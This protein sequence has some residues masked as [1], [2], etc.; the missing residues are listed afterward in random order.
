MSKISFTRFEPDAND[1]DSVLIEEFREEIDEEEFMEF[2]STLDIEKC[3]DPSIDAPSCNYDCDNCEIECELV[4]KDQPGKEISLNVPLMLEK[5][6]KHWI[7][8][9]EVAEI[10][11][12][13]KNLYFS[14]LNS[15]IICLHEMFYY[16]ICD[17]G[18]IDLSSCVVVADTS[19][20]VEL[21]FRFC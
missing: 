18:E 12:M 5:F 21:D 16:S 2:L 1:K 13:D 11:D 9:K 3:K 19:E 8:F 4:Y 10:V 14:I 15:E 20:F 6:N 17:A 7:S